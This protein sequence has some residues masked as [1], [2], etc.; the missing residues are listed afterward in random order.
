M[1]LYQKYQAMSIGV[2]NVHGTHPVFCV[3]THILPQLSNYD[4]AQATY[5]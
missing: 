1:G 4:E 3:L 2:H 5:I